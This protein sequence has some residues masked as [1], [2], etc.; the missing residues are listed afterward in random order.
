MENKDDYFISNDILTLCVE[1]SIHPVILNKML[2]FIYTGQVSEIDKDSE[3]LF[4]VA[5]MYQLD[6]LK[7][8]CVFT[9][10]YAN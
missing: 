2:Q 7:I 3:E 10:L 9:R 8:L 1:L 6:K 4:K 5:D